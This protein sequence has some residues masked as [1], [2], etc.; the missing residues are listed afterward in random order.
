MK[1]RNGIVWHR[2][3][4]CKKDGVCLLPMLKPNG[5]VITCAFCGAQCYY[6]YREMGRTGIENA[7]NNLVYLV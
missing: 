3:G 6:S 2:C 7:C 1:V 4:A 5:W